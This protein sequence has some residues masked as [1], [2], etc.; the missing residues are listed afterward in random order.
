M[1]YVLDASAVI[2]FLW[3]E[4]GADMVEQ[5]LDAGRNHCFMHAV[6]VCEVY[7]DMVLRAEESKALEIIERLKK[8]ISVRVDMDE[9]FWQQAGSFKASI[10]RI[11]LADCFCL[12]LSTRL[13]AVVLTSDHHE[14]DRVVSRH[15]EHI[16]FIR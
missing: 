11:S 14:F 13:K 12:S 8:L 3:G 2:A 16:K 5:S 1:R 9:P 6:N 10:R 15:G 4:E 7:Y